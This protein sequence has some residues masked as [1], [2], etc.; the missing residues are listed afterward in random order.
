MLKLK[1]K[2]IQM[3]TRDSHR[4][5]QSVQTYGNT[6]DSVALAPD[7]CTASVTSGAASGV[8]GPGAAL[9]VLALVGVASK[10]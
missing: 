1:F 7:G 3:H 5:P 9:E 10:P 2:N 6:E 4:V 8:E